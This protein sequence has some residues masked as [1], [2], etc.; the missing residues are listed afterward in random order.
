[1]NIYIAILD[2]T[3]CARSNFS[4]SVDAT[5]FDVSYYWKLYHNNDSILITTYDGKMKMNT[6]DTGLYVLS[7]LA[8]NNNPPFCSAISK[9]TSIYIHITP[10]ASFIIDRKSDSIK[11]NTDTIP[12]NIILID[13][14]INATS[15]LWHF[16][17]GESS[18]NN[19]PVVNYTTPGQY[20]IQLIAYNG[21]CS[22][23]A[24]NPIKIYPFFSIYVP[25]A[26]TPNNDGVNDFFDIK[27]NGYE[28]YTFTIFNRWGERVY[29]GHKNDIGWDGTFKG[30]LCNQDVY[31][32]VL[33]NV[34]YNNVGNLN[35]NTSNNCIDCNKKNLSGDIHLLR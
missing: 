34:M 15:Y 28:D 1:M 29:V 7:L 21:I 14:S 9:T 23:T 32:W 25:N 16:G 18:F 22:D 20:K 10:R 3:I 6:K 33:S 2:T 4:I 12:A 27:V 19:N 26:F 24:E 31:L 17:N 13:K 30:K 35:I 8:S 5:Y 11:F